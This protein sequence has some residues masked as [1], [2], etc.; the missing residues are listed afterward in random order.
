MKPG[1]LRVSIFTMSDNMFIKQSMMDGILDAF[2]TPSMVDLREL[3]IFFC[4]LLDFCARGLH[5]WEPFAQPINAP[6]ELIKK[7]SFQ[8]VFRIGRKEVSPGSQTGI[9]MRMRL[10]NPTSV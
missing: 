9:F 2:F 4:N 10:R 6:D 7:S 5:D 3:E 8:Q 1:T